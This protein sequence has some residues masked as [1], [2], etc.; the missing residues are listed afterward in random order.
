MS[1]QDSST[2]Y[3]Q[4]GVVEIKISISPFT[5]KNNK[6]QGLILLNYK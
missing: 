4:G 1:M 6:K 3:L 5:Q 2:V